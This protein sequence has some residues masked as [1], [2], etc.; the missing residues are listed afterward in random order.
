MAVEGNVLKNR[1]ISFPEIKSIYFDIEN[2]AVDVVRKR[3]V[4][5]S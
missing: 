5:F 1:I 2:V 3:N 4:V